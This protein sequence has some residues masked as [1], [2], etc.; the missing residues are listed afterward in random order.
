MNQYDLDTTILVLVDICRHKVKCFESFHLQVENDMNDQAKRL[1]ACILCCLQTT[2]TNFHKR[3][4][5][6][7][8]EILQVKMMVSRM[9]GLILKDTAYKLP[10][11]ISSLLWIYLVLLT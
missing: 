9:T 10:H 1:H 2:L 6:H 8:G 5:Q 11:H 7:W 3:Q 4:E